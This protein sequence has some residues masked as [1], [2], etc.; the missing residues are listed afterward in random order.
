MVPTFRTGAS[1]R[2]SLIPKAYATCGCLLYKDST[3]LVTVP[4]APSARKVCLLS[5][6]RL[7]VNTTPITELEYTSTSKTVQDV[8]M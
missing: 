1:S 8:K 7:F 2:S 3:L 5:I 6:L 4:L